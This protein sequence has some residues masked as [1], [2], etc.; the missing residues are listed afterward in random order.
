MTQTLAHFL[1]C[2]SSQSSESFFV[3]HPL[4][5]QNMASQLSA[6]DIAYIFLIIINTLLFTPIGIR[7]TIRYFKK[8][9]EH[10]YRSRR[11]LLVTISNVCYL[12]YISLYVPIHVITMELIWN[13]NDSVYEWWEI[14]LHSMLGELIFVAIAL[15]IWHSFY[16]FQ[17][18]NSVSTMGWKAILNQD[19]QR[20]QL[21]FAF[22]YKRFLG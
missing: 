9:R 12:L 6:L 3:A 8:R 18:A 7:M 11:P 13:D 22:K 4:T 19:Y 20:A 21:S 5:E 2:L 1:K 14:G 17:L 10:M 15:R 16:D